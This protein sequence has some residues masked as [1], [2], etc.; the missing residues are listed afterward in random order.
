MNVLHGADLALAEE[1]PVA[2]VVNGISHAVIW[3]TLLWGS[4]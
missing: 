1:V 4:P 3:K 2:F